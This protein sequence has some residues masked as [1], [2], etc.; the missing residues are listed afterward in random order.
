MWAHLL[1]FR[2]PPFNLQCWVGGGLFVAD[3][4]FMIYLNPL[5]ILNFITCLYTIE[6]QKYAFSLHPPRN[7]GLMVSVGLWWDG[8]PLAPKVPVSDRPSL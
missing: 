5:K 2:G 7:F 8:E 1:D 3:K 4:L 6:I